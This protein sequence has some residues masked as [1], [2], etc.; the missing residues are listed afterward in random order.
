MTNRWIKVVAVVI[1]L[2]LLIAAP[3]VLNSFYLR[4]LGEI[5]IFSILAM[6]LNLLVGYTGLTSLGHAALFGVG[7][8]VV[9]YTTANLGFPFLVTVILGILGT[10]LVTAIFGLLAV[11]TSG[12]YFLM[13]TLALGMIVWGLAFRWNSVTNAE[14]GIRG[15]VR[16]EFLSEYS[17]YYYLVLI[18]LLIVIGLIYRIVNSPFG[19]TLQGIRESAGRMRT[20]GYNVTLHKYLGF[21]LAGSFAGLAGSLYAFHNNFISPPTVAFARSAQV[22]LMV[23]L[24]GVG[25][26]LGPVVGATVIIFGQYQLSL[27]TDRWIMIMGAIYV[28]TILIAPDGLVGVWRRL[29]GRLNPSDE[30]VQDAAPAA[31]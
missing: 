2:G 17:S 10:M 27:F 12:I 21:M 16:P 18:V 3:Q 11:R 23:I 30:K 22:L 4:V 20:L 15:I 8:Y 7:A 28:I 19:L 26:I 1:V 25:T 29:T 31:D 6:S 24:G 13:I 14:N 5:L 9:G